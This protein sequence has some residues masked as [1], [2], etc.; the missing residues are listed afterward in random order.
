MKF[1][2]SFLSPKRDVVIYLL[3]VLRIKN[4]LNV[5]SNWEEGRKGQGKEG[6]KG[7]RKESRKKQEKKREKAGTE[8]EETSYQVIV[9]VWIAVRGP[10]VKCSTI[11]YPGKDKKCR[12]IQLCLPMSKELPRWPRR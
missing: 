2:G 12:L 4:R 3:S 9:K 10:R 1:K 6:R 7:Q 5:H 8:M 11:Q